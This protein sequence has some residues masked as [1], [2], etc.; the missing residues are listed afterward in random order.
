MERLYPNQIGNNLKGLLIGFLMG[1]VS[2]AI[3]VLIS[4][5][6]HDIR[7]SFAGFDPLLFICF[8]LAV[9]I[10][11]SGE[12]LVMRL[13]LYQKLRRRYTNVIFIIIA[14]SFVFMFMHAGNPG[15]TI[16]A[17]SQIFLS[18]VIGCLLVY[19]YDSIWM[20]FT[21]H[22]AWNFTQSIIFGLPNSGKVSAYSLFALDEAS[23]RNGLL[24]NVDFGVEGSIGSSL[25]LLV[26]VFVI[27]YINRGKTERND[28]W[29]DLERAQLLKAEQNGNDAV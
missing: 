15:F 3:C 6:K 10:Q 19:Y 27:I 28:I 21:H 16:V 7:L 2:N 17:G 8:M 29:A 14:V 4:V 1:F 5:L 20:A 13:Y 11:S 23:A 12:E 18:S 24:Y 22:M 26:M 9:L 25:V